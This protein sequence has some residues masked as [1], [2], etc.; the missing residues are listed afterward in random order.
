MNNNKEIIIYWIPSHIEV[1]GNESVDSAAKS[2]L[3]LTSDKFRIPYTHLK[4]IINKFLTQNG[5]NGGIITRII[6]FCKS[7]L[8]W[9]NGDQLSENQKRT[10]P[11]IPIVHWQYS[12]FYTETGPTTTVFDMSNALHH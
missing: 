1:G 3:D 7:S 6:S 2:V 4:P 11:Y 9:E 8:L 10:N 5:N 12:L